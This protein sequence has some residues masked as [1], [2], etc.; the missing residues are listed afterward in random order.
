MEMLMQP[1]KPESELDGINSDS[2]YLLIGL[3]C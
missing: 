1:W 2:W 3:Y